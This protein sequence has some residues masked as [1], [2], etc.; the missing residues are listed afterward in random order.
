MNP[1]PDVS[2]PYRI[3]AL[4]QERNRLFAYPL[5]QIASDIWSARFRCSCCGAC[6]TRSVNNHIFLL[7]HDVAE[8]KT[9]DPGAYVP[10]PD[11]E[12]CDQNGM[13]YVSGYALRMKDDAAGS[14]WF[15]ENGKCSIYDS[16]FSGCRIYPHMLR[17]SAGVSGNVTWR[18]FA[19]KGS[20]GQFDP[21]LSYDECLAIAREIKEYENAYL[22]HQISFLETIHEYF[23][24]CNLRHDPA[25]YQKH[26]RGYGQGRPIEIKVFHAGELEEYRVAKSE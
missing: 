13:F 24:L 11:P 26:M 10:A 15:L 1:A 7:D 22:T 19:R 5:E 2:I 12:F 23:I 17:R 9:I 8:L 16:R 20:H 3:V 14:C 4:M 21:S 25:V 18:Q 6:C